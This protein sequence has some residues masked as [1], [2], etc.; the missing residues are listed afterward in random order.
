VRRWSVLIAFVVGTFLWAGAVWRIIGLA[1]GA[2]PASAPNEES[3]GIGKPQPQRFGKGA[4]KGPLEA[5][6]A[7]D[8]RA[9]P[10]VTGRVLDRPEGHPVANISVTLWNGYR[11]RNAEATTDANGQY[12]FERVPPSEHYKVWINDRSLPPATRTEHS[13]LF[14]LDNTAV[15]VPDLCMTWPQRITGTVRDAETG[16]PVAGAGLNFSTIDRNRDSV[17]ADEQGHYCLYVRPR[18]VSIRCSGTPDRYQSSRRHAG[19]DGVSGDEMITVASGQ[20]V[21]GVDF[22]IQSGPKLTGTVTN[23]DGSP[24]ADIRVTV[25]GTWRRSFDFGSGHVFSATTNAAG[26]YYVYLRAPSRAEHVKVEV[27]EIVVIARSADGARA[28]FGAHEAE[29]GPTAIAVEPIT[30]HQTGTVTLNLIDQAGN[31]ITGLRIFSYNSRFSRPDRH[32]GVAEDLGKGHYR[33]SQLVPGI[34]Q[35][36]RHRTEG[37]RERVGGAQAFTL[38]PGETRELGT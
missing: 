25:Y 14:V 5:E 17:R 6:A 33:V 35:R 13:E 11:G 16:Y 20:H 4:V 21:G 10:F 27:I 26:E 3:A 22:E 23:P 1:V 19:N 9:V 34:K 29:S 15:R 18:T 30:V 7:L 8:D 31:P 37:Y 12:V 32:M 24:A 38:G 36:V 2:P 28:G